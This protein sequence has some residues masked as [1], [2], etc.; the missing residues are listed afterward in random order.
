MMGSRKLAVAVALALGCGFTSVACAKTVDMTSAEN[1]GG[2]T[3]S[4]AEYGSQ[5]G[6]SWQNPDHYQFGYDKAT[7]TVIG[8]D[9]TLAEDMTKVTPSTWGNE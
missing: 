4:S 1:L 2:I 5:I 9:I 6:E 8:G 7:G 3:W